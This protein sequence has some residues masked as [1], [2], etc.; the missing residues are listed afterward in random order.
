M[1]RHLLSIAS[2]A[3]VAGLAHAAEGAVKSAP[4]TARPALASGIATRY[5]ES[6]VRPQ[7]DFFEYLNGKWLKTVD[8][9]ADK[10]YLD[11]FMDRYE[12]SLL[13]LRE[14]IEK[15]AAGTIKDGDARRIGDFYASFMDEAKLE[16]L[17]ITPLRSELD[18]IAAVKDKAELA[19]VLAHLGRLGMGVPLDVTVHLDNKDST[20]YVADISQGGLGL[21]DP[22]YFLKADDQ[23]LA[24]MKARYLAHCREVLAMA[25]DADAAA[26]AQAIVDFETAL[27]NAQWTTVELRDPNK[28]Y[29][30]FQLADLPAFAPGFDWK[31]WLDGIGLSGKSTYVIVGQPSYLKAFAG[32]AAATPLDTWK[33][34]L[35]LHLVKSYSRFLS[36]AFVDADFEFFDKTLF[37]IDA[38]EPRWK[39]GVGVIEATQGDAL[40]KLYVNRYFPQ[41]R[42]ARIEH[43]MGNLMAAYKASIDKLD[44]MSPT[45]KVE[46]QAK[47]AKMK[48]KIGY[49][50]TW[51]DYSAL[52]VER[53]DLVGNVMRSRELEFD[54][55]LA[56]L[57]KPIDRNEWNVTPQTVNAYY[58]PEKNE[59]V[60]PAAVLQ[61]PIF[62]AAADDAV[63]YGAIGA[64]LGHEISHGFDDRGS[65]YDGDGNLRDWWTPADREQ[66]K[67]KAS[68]LVSQYNAFEPIPGYY[69]NGELTLG[70]NIADISGLAIAYKAYHLS[71]KGKKAPVIDGLTGDQRLYM[72]FG[73]IWR[74]K[75]RDN[76]Q[77]M[78]LKADPHSPG[79]FRTIGTLRNNPGFYET[80]G[81]K[82]GDRMYLPPKDRVSIW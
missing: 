52:V 63:N 70:E 74:Q 67:A 40:G 22:D 8:I 69:V 68:M 46:A 48:T 7:D 33:A 30:K 82:P 72:G 32:I 59:I 19:G 35:T 23:K 25:G 36:K 18:R 51:K 47:L 58:N 3:L 11:P 53:D 42:K 81:V 41:D 55:D 12:D 14:I 64:V 79:R 44:W 28:A 77:I 45:T 38:N 61:P 17:G 56:K 75:M 21:P 31:R 73:Q 13:Q 57:N 24:D 54:R 65:Q 26:H 78:L 9:P 76:T 50:D 5:I 71:L 80:F 10:P 39:R 43:L 29:N 49:P 6:S 1:Q 27:A 37:G 34:Y 16:Q 66:F 62:D 4:A 20:R 15:A 60:V 2:L